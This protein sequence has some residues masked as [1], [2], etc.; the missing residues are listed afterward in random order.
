MNVSQV[1]KLVG[2]VI[3]GDESIEIKRALS[4]KDAETGSI[5]FVSN[6]KYESM[7]A[8]TKASCVLV[9]EDFSLETDITVVKTKDPSYAFAQVLS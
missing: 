7:L 6:P 3:N 5:T 9:S 1:A 4:I 8:S 2:G